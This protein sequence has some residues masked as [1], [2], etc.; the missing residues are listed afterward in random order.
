MLFL[1]PEMLR[2]TASL[3]V[4]ICKVIKRLCFSPDSVL[5]FQRYT[6]YTRSD[7]MPHQCSLIVVLEF[8]FDWKSCFS[9][10]ETKS[11]LTYLLL[12]LILSNMSVWLRN[13]S[14]ICHTETLGKRRAFHLACP[15]GVPVWCSSKCNHWFTRLVVCFMILTE[16]VWL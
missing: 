2:K 9:H 7:E 6:E 13:M 8:I 5:T 14:R 12:V 11:L 10:Q 15:V 4:Q 16:A 3:M 1:F